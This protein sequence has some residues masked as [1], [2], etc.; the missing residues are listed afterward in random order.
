MRKSFGMV[1]GVPRSPQRRIK[2]S[3]FLVLVTVKCRPQSRKRRSPGVKVEL[4]PLCSTWLT[5]P[6]CK[7]SNPGWASR[8]AVLLMR[9]ENRWGLQTILQNCNSPSAPY[10]SRPLN[11]SLYSGETEVLSN[12]RMRSGV[13]PRW[14]L[15]TSCH[16]LRRLVWLKCSVLTLEKCLMVRTHFVWG[17]Y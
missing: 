5:P 15:M 14:I 8:Y 9:R 13:F 3:Q 4:L 16:S 17:G 7:T 12:R 10:S 6:I 11:G 1:A 2:Y